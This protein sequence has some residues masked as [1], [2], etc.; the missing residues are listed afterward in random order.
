LV[1]G[2]LLRVALEADSGVRMIGLRSELANLL[3]GTL[4]TGNMAQ[5]LRCLQEGVE[6]VAEVLST[7]G[8]LIRVRVRPRT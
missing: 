5:L 8:R 2:E 6:F 7:D 1:V 4:T 3:V